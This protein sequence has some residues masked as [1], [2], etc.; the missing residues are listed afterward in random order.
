[1]TV[2]SWLLTQTVRL[3]GKVWGSN[4][5]TT[6]SQPSATSATQDLIKERVQEKSES[7]CSSMPTEKQSGGCSIQGLWLL[8]VEV[9]VRVIG[10]PRP[11]V[12]RWGT[13]TPRAARLCEDQIRVML[14]SEIKK[15]SL[16]APFEGCLEAEVKA[17]YEV[18]KS[19]TKRNR[20]ECLLGLDYVRDYDVDNIAKTVLDAANELVWK[21][22]IQVVKLTA[23]KHYATNSRLLFRVRKI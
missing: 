7:E 4:P 6:E 3:T 18:P 12:T 2:L 22:D 8:E 5:M 14:I 9:P 13:Y 20:A 10:K 19:R 15:K 21:S 23:E 17:Y 16:K 11:R 1:M